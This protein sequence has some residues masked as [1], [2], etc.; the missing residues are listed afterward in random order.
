MLGHAG[1]T[2]PTRQHELPDHS[3]QE[4]ICR[5]RSIDHSSGIDGL[6]DV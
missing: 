1:F 4:S 5:E 3:D 6:S 2:A